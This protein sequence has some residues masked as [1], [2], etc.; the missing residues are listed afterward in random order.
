MNVYLDCFL[1]FA[2][3]G[4]FTIGGGYAMI[5]VVQKE[6]VE[7]KKWID[8]TEFVDM[9]AVAQATPGAW[10]VNV[11][12]FVGYKLKKNKGS[13][14]AA[15]GTILPSFLIIL[16]IAIFFSRFQDNIWVAK[17][18]NA[19]R[20]AVVAL[21]AVP[22]FTTARQVKINVKTAIIPVVAAILIWQFGVSPVYIVLA[23]GFAGW[24]YGY[25]FDRTKTSGS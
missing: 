20:P 10:A 17:M 9:L 15:L 7:K 6:V 25:F 3:I 11:A 5:P 1:T 19:I 21:I 12:V 13:L 24:I 14:V 2:K 18:F 4:A 23:A 22:V 16:L 8:G